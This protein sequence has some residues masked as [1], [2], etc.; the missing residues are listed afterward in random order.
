MRHFSSPIFRRMSSI[1]AFR[2]WRSGNLESAAV[3]AETTCQDL[4]CRWAWMLDWEASCTTWQYHWWHTDASQ[5][6]E[7]ATTSK[8]DQLERDAGRILDRRGCYKSPVRHHPLLRIISVC[9]FI[10]GRRWIILPRW[11][12][13]CKLYKFGLPGT[14]K[15]DKLG[16][17]SVILGLA[18]RVSTAAGVSVFEAVTTLKSRLIQWGL[19]LRLSG[20]LRKASVMSAPTGPNGI[21]RLANG[22]L[23][24][25]PPPVVSDAVWFCTIRTT[26]GISM[27]L[28]PRSPNS[29]LSPL[30]PKL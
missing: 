7:L 26:P 15:L 21:V 2:P 20:L 12:L 16:L 14:P 1:V 4:W 10:I 29:T 6:L 24:T 8:A 9:S 3:R 11:P 27:V 17:K 23:V 30:P 22:P 28:K 13:P 18:S 5:G 25:Q 19:Y